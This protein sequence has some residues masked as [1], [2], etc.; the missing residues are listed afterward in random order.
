MR[1]KTV[2]GS[3]DPAILTDR[4]MSPLWILNDRE[5]SPVWLPSVDNVKSFMAKWLLKTSEMRMV[6]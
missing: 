6:E 5:M 1:S 2:G 3:S 4:E